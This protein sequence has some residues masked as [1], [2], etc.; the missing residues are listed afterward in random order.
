MRSMRVFLWSRRGVD[1]R[2]VLKA[3]VFFLMS[4]F[5]FFCG[6]CIFGVV[7]DVYRSMTLLVAFTGDEKM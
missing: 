1:V 6:G 7:D 2:E 5:V 3:W 4:V